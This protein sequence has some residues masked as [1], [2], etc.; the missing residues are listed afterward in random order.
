MKKIY[1]KPFKNDGK[2]AAFYGGVR[3]MRKFN[4][5]YISSI[6]SFVFVCCYLAGYALNDHPNYGLLEIILYGGALIWFGY[7]NWLV[8][9]VHIAVAGLM[10]FKWS[11][12]YKA[13]LISGLL[14]L[15]FQALIYCLFHNGI[16]LSA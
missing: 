13:V 7:V 2:N 16:G 9:L 5:A 15:L 10:K 1:N 6:V 4:K 14:V 8:G 11:R 3:C 12:P